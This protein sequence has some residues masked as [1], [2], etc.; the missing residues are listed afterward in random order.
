MWL[1]FSSCTL[2]FYVI[3]QVI[4]REIAFTV[5]D[6]GLLY[7]EKYANNDYNG[8]AKIEVGKSAIA[9]DCLTFFGTKI[10]FSLVKYE[11][12]S[13]SMNY[14]IQIFMSNISQLAVLVHSFS[15]AFV[16]DMKFLWWLLS[17]VKQH[18]TK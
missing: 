14:S 13:G 11:G 5:S 6:A 12:I 1:L 4:T 2:S 7:C 9:M 17:E 15:I 18:Y 3:L 16:W 8:T 10:G